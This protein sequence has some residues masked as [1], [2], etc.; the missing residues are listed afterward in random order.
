MNKL[1][2]AVITHQADT[3]PSNSIDIEKLEAS[4]GFSLSDEYREY[5]QEFGIIAYQAYETYGLGVKSNSFLHVLNAY[6]DLSR[7]KTYPF[8]S[9]P[10]LEIGD[11]QYYLYD[12]THRQI[13]IWATPNGGVIRKLETN[14]EDFLLTKIFKS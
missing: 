13:I 11:G 14:F 1:R 10:L 12:N 9:V 3:R 5:L 2:A 8:T 7:D 6:Q 4:L